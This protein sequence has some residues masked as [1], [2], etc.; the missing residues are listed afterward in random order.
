[1][2]LV[3]YRIRFS[4]CPICKKSVVME[5][6]GDVQYTSYIFIIFIYLVILYILFHAGAA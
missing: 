5:M 3:D 2:F 4:I 1:M 6:N